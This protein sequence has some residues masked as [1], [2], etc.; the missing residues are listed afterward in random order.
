MKKEIETFE[1]VQ[2]LVRS[3]Y[4]KV[5]EDK[6]LSHFFS[7]VR[8]HHWNKHLSVLDTFWNNVLFYS[9]DYHGNP[10]QVHTILHHFNNLKN[11]DF[12]RWLYLFYQTVD[13]LFEG[14]KAEL[15]KQRAMSIA[16][17]MRIK[18]LHADSG[19]AL[20]IISANSN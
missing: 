13:E 19:N 1:D 10:L 16:T 2:L 7:Y 4:N 17:I 5:L 12:D 15:A 3:F 20:P 6:T 18:I 9:G 11:T 8:K 14:E